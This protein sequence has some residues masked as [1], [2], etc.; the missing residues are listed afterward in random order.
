M[1]DTYDDILALTSRKPIWWDAH[2]VPRYA[3]FH[4]GIGAHGR[5][6]ECLL[7]LARARG[8]PDYLQLMCGYTAQF[9]RA[10]QLTRSKSL[11]MGEPPAGLHAENG[12]I[13]AEP[14]KVLEYWRRDQDPFSKW[15][16]LPEFEIDLID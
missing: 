5:P 8:G 9:E 15:Q 7:V 6:N 12:D 2:D 1:Y 10:E 3:P 4:P 16:R 13:S 14:V 11:P